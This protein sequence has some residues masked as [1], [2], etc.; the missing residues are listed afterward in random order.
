MAGKKPFLIESSMAEDSRMALED[1]A[2]GTQ[3]ENP[4]IGGVTAF[5]RADNKVEFRKFGL[6]VKNT[7]RASR[8]A[9]QLADSLLWD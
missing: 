2:A 1:L 4:I 3:D 8:I 5:V 7:D 9:H 6:C